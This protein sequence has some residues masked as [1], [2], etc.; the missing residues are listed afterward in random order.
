[1]FDWLIK[2]FF[3]VEDHVAVGWNPG[4]GCDTLLLRLIPDLKSACPIDR[5][6]HYPAFYIVRLHC[7]T[8]TL[9]TTCH[10]GSQFVP[11]LWWSSVWP[12][13]DAN[14]RPTTWEVDMLITKPFQHSYMYWYVNSLGNQCISHGFHKK[15]GWLWGMVSVMLLNFE[16]NDSLMRYP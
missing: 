16:N 14:P 7:Q 6:T 13:W 15:N 8:P 5:S 2:C 1:M 9:I 4:P 11:Y 3:S 10:A 12:G